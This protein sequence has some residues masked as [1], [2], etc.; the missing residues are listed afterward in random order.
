VGPEKLAKRKF[1]SNAQKFKVKRK[2]KHQS[3]ELRIIQCK[4]TRKLVRKVVLLAQ[5]SEK[6][7]GKLIFYSAE[8][9]Y[10]HQNFN[11]N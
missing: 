4:T 9:L 7:R 1:C 5:I 10:S 6:F 2:K 8:H 3:G 11:S